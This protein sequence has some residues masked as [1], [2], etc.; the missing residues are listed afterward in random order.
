MDLARACASSPRRGRWR[1]TLRSVAALCTALLAGAALTGA[2]PAGADT[3]G[4]DTPTYD[5]T[6][7]PQVHYSPAQNW[8]NDPN[9][10]IFHQGEY[11]YF[12]QYNPSGN[13]WGN[14]SWGHATSTDLVHWKQQPVAIPHNDDEMV[15]SGSVVLDRSNS[16]GFGTAQSPPLV[17][18][19]TSHFKASGKQAQSL[20][21]SRD[22]GLSWTR[23]AANPV[24]DIGSVNFR[25]PKV[26]WYA[27]TKS[28]LMVV[29]LS[30]QHKVSFY[31][32][33]DLK[34]WTHLSDFGPQ[35]A[36][37]G[38][39]E[40]PDLF[41]LA[42][43]GDPRKTKWVLV[44][45][46]NPGGIAGGS[47]AQYFTGTF[48]GTRFTS[49]DHGYTPP[50][51]TVLADFEGGDYGGWSATGT[52]FGTAPATGALPDQQTVSGFLGRGLANSFLQHDSSTGTLTSPVFTVDKPYLNFLVGG[53]NHPH[54]DGAGDGSPPPG[55]VFADFEGPT[56]GQ[57][58]TA[59]GD[60]TDAGPT[61][62][63]LSGQIGSRILDTCVKTCDPATGTI[64][65]PSFTITRKY[66]DFLIAGGNH[67]WGGDGATAV[68]L[69]VDG[70]VVKTA[71]GNNSGTM[72]WTSWDVSTLAGK[73]AQLQV[74]DNATGGWGHLMVDHL[75]HSDQA[76][77]PRDVQTTVNL[78]VDN[79]VVRTATGQNSEMLDWTSWNLKDLIG[80]SAQIQIVDAGNGDWGH[81]LADQFMTAD[82]PATNGIQRAHWVDYGAD[83]YAAV[84]YNDAPAGKRIMHAWM[85]NWN[86]GGNI[87]TSPWRSAASFPRELSLKTIDGKPQLVSQPVDALASLRRGKAAKLDNT[88]VRSRTQTV[89]GGGQVLEI[90]TVLRQ[91]D[92]KRFG[93]NVR[94]GKGQLTQ[95]GYDTTTSELYIDRTASGNVTFDA[96][97]PGVHRAP[98]PLDHGQLKLRIIVDASSVEVYAGQGQVTLTDQIFP[99]PASTGLSVFANDGSAQVKT[100]T[101]W[102]LASTWKN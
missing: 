70:Q 95:I 66:I 68:N 54:V 41:P 28:W 35:N 89:R 72:D 69:I 77:K 97:F 6:Y 19:Y 88:T 92:A 74:V 25:D 14:M 38:L 12:Y 22:G 46:L 64:T 32:S 16:T 5:E 4:A 63:N 58:W 43:D 2:V 81:V 76:A 94:T 59:T 31:S 21:Y 13:T 80:K 71:T 30:D 26:F 65:S 98:L 91:L 47:G 100:L 99:D 57:G 78:L 39:W 55:E 85:N 42:V 49:D 29:A 48:N 102:H 87:P 60:F 53:G 62:G 44:V 86:Y 7:R 34:S 90:H 93:I 10:L 23:H 45:N 36:V 3:A 73:T 18:V 67:P 8:M 15:Y 37:G 20:A 50:S 1:R 83:F 33:R 40:C 84:T 75:V 101:A 96:T 52:A 9:G 11:H 79:R 17:A 56:W 51:G 24:L 61:T 82:A 27:P